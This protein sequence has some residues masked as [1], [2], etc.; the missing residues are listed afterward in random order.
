MFILGCRQG[1]HQRT[2]SRVGRDR[3]IR[4]WEP[5]HEEDL[6]ATVPHAQ[7]ESRRWLAHPVRA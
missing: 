3:G 5:G 7:E 4:K 6:E 1:A 2:K